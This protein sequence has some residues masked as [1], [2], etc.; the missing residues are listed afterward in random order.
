MFTRLL[1]TDETFS[2]FNSSTSRPISHAQTRAPADT[3]T[4]S[5]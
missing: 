1:L 2:K 4:H 5:N 3:R